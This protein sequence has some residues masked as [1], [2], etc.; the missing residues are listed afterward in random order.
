MKKVVNNF[1]KM[2]AIMLIMTLSL[3]ITSYASMTELVVPEIMQSKDQW[4]WAAAAEMA[5]KYK[6]SSSSRTQDDIVAYIKGSS[7]INK[8]GSIFET[9]DSIEYVT[10]DNYDVTSTWFSSWSFSK[11][12]TSIDN[13]YPVVPLV[14]DGNSGHFYVI[15]GYDDST[16]EIALNDPWDG[17]RKVVKW[18][19]FDSG[20]WSD[21]RPHKHTVYFSDYD[22]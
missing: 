9:A 16:D 20:D 15:R 4:C 5:G 7:S 18:N 22:D 8:P 2:L 1:T 21:S 19:D 12:K 14:N 10:Y 17:S 3:T 13:G 6:Y 11:V